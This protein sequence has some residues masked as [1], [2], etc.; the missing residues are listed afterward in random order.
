MRQF[1]RDGGRLRLPI[2]S[3]SGRGKFHKILS[4]TRHG[5]HASLGRGD[6]CTQCLKKTSANDQKPPG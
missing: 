2:G 5:F 6:P 3:D 4:E 1:A